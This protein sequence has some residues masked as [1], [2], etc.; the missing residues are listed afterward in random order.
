MA[1]LHYIKGKTGVF[2]HIRNRIKAILIP[3]ALAFIPDKPYGIDDEQ[4]SKSL[5]V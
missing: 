3:E 4:I 1:Y 2:E 5:I